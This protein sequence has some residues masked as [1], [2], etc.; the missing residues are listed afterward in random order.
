M[1]EEE[2]CKAKVEHVL[3][4]VVEEEVAPAME[5]Q[6]G[7]SRVLLRG[8][9]DGTEVVWKPAPKREIRFYEEVYQRAPR[10]VEFIPRYFGSHGRGKDMCERSR[11]SAL[12]CLENLTSPFERP[13]VLDVKMGT[14]QQ[15]HD[16]P[17]AKAV[18][19][20]KKCASTTSGQ[21]GFRLCGM[22]VWQPD[23]EGGQYLQRDKYYGRRVRVRMIDLALAEFFHTG[24][25]LREDIIHEVQRRLGMLLEAMQQHS[26]HRFYSA[27]LLI[28]FEGDPTVAP[29]VD[30]RMIDFAHTCK[31]RS[32]TCRGPDWGF[33]LGLIELRETLARV[34]SAQE[35]L[36]R[37]LCT[38][39]VCDEASSQDEP[40]IEEDGGTS[41]DSR[42][43]STSS[44]NAGTQGSDS[45]GDSSGDDTDDDDGTVAVVAVATTSGP[46]VDNA[47]D[48]PEPLCR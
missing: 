19:M 40:P 7:G 3:E 14:Q 16:A 36:S 17:P 6:V 32:H 28:L 9:R 12:V 35:A 41:D 27:S 18:R 25:M 2:V 47:C 11:E 1:H 30:V 39:S 44:E 20:Q 38:E 42:C 33:I 48:S 8:N 5:H 43:S 31:A 46:P 24:R 29:K 23:K 45:S 13:C 22:K 15:G 10:L 37:M 26:G 21:L 4:H 34:L